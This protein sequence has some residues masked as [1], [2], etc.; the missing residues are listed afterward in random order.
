MAARWAGQ[1]PRAE[2]VDVPGSSRRSVQLAY[3]EHEASGQR[4]YQKVTRTI[5]LAVWAFYGPQRWHTPWAHRSWPRMQPP[6]ATLRKMPS[7]IVFRLRASSFL[8][9]VVYTRQSVPA[10]F[11]FKAGNG[12]KCAVSFLFCNRWLAFIHFRRENIEW[13]VS[14][15]RELQDLEL[16]LSRISRLSF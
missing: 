9:Y 3:S 10:L 11:W 4:W 12:F 6:G 7:R 16:I 8:Y 5:W 15:R 2:H 13:Y 14:L 1:R